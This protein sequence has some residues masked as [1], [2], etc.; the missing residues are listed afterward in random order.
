MFEE[1]FHEKRGMCFSGVLPSHDEDDGLAFFPLRGRQL[2]LLTLVV[3]LLVGAARG[4]CGS[5]GYTLVFCL[6][7]DEVGDLVVP[8][9]VCD[10][11][12]GPF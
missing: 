1:A 3:D 4:R 7:Y 10:G 11:A 6:S 2:F 12:L 9:C 5:S 8:Q